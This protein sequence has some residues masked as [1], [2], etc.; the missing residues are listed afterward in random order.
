MSFVRHL[1]LCLWKT[2]LQKLRNPVSA[3]AELLL[4]VVLVG[5]WVFLYT[6]S[7]LTFMPDATH[8]CNASTI[9]DASTHQDF[10]YLPRALNILN[11]KLAVVGPPELTGPFY[12][13]LR[14]TYP[15]IPAA[16]VQTL[17]CQKSLGFSR[18]LGSVPRLVDLVVNFTTEAEMEAQITS[19]NYGQAASNPLIYAAIVWNRGPPHWDYTIRMNKTA[20]PDNGVATDPYLQGVQM[21]TQ[22]SYVS[23][24]PATDQ[25][26]QWPKTDP[27]IV[28]G[29][30]AIQLAVD[31]FVL[32]VREA[33]TEWAGLVTYNSTLAQVPSFLALWNCT[34]NIPLE[35]AGDEGGNIVT[36]I[37]DMMNFLQSHSFSP[38]QALLVPFPTASYYSTTFY[39]V[40]ANVFSLSFILFFFYPVSQLISGVVHEKETRIKEGMRMMGIPS[41]AL[42]AAWYI[43]YALAFLVASF[44]VSAVASKS[45]FGRSDSYVVWFMFWLFGLAAT[46]EA[47]LISVFFSRAKVASAVGTIVFLASF[48]PYYAVNDPTKPF[49]NKLGACFSAP[50][51]LGLNLQVLAQLESSGIGLHWSTAWLQVDG[52]T[53]GSGMLMMFLDTVLYTVIALYLEQVLPSEYGVPKPWYFPCTSR[54]WASC[55][56]CG[57][58]RIV[59]HAHLGGMDVEASSAGDISLQ[60]MGQDDSN[61]DNRPL[62]DATSDEEDHAYS[63][64]RN[65]E[66]LGPDRRALKAAGRCVSARNLQKHFQTPDGIRKAVDGVDLDVFQGEIFALLGHNGAG[67]STT[68]S[69]LTGLIPMS[70]GAANAFGLDVRTDMDQLR[71]ILGVCPQHD[72]LW[73]ELTVQEHLTFFAAAKGVPPGEVN[74]AVEETIKEVG[75]TEKRTVQSQALSGGMKRKLSVG[76]ALIGG[77]KLVVLDEPTSGMDPYSR[78]STW[79]ILLSSKSDRA[80]ILSTHFLDEA[81]LLGDR[82]AIMASGK[83]RC[84]GSSM[85]LKK[86]YGV[87]YNLTVNKADESVD[88]DPV[89]ALIRKHVSTV[90]DLSN[91]GAEIAFQV[92][93]DASPRF[94]ALFEE[95]ESKK[96]DLGVRSYSIGVTTL[97]EVFLRVAEEEHHGAS[98][99]TQKARDEAKETSNGF[100]E[101]PSSKASAAAAGGY[102]PPSDAKDGGAYLHPAAPAA[103]ADGWDFS[104]PVAA[105]GPKKVKPKVSHKE[106]LA[107]ARADAKG[108][109]WRH[110]YALFNKRLRYAMRDLRAAIFQ[111]LIPVLALLAGLLLLKLNPVQLPPPIAFN[112]SSLN[113]Q[114]HSTS[115]QAEPWSTVMQ[116]P[117][118]QN[119]SFWS[120]LV[121]STPPSNATF[122]QVPQP[123]LDAMYPVTGN[124]TVDDL[125]HCPAL[126]QFGVWLWNPVDCRPDTINSSIFPFKDEEWSLKRQSLAERIQSLSAAP[127]DVTPGA[128]VEREVAHQPNSFASLLGVEAGP[129]A[130]TIDLI[131]QHFGTHRVLEAATV[132]KEFVSQLR[133]GQVEVQGPAGKVKPSG[134]FGCAKGEWPHP[135]DQAKQFGEYLLN[136]RQSAPQGA[137]VYAALNVTKFDIVPGQARKTPAF[138]VSNGSAGMVLYHNT[139]ANHAIPTFINVFTSAAW[140]FLSGAGSSAQLASVTARSNPVPFTQ[141]EKS[142]QNS[143]SSFVAVLFI[144]LAFAFIPASFAVF[145]VR[146]REVS[147]KHLQLIS[148]VSIPAYWSATFCWDIANYAVPCSLSIVLVAAFNVQELIEGESLAAT[149]LLFVLY[150]IS[151]AAFT[152][153]LSYLFTSHAT[154]QIVVLVLNLLCMILLIASFIMQQIDSTCDADRGLRYIYRFLPG[155][156]LGNGLLQLSLLKQLAFLNTDCSRGKPDYNPFAAPALT[157]FSADVA[158]APIGYMAAEA[159]LY[160]ILAVALDLILSSPASRAR[161]KPDTDTEQPPFEEDEDVKKERLR[162]ESG[163]AADDVIV[164]DGL[165]KVYGGE[166]AAIKQLSFGVGGGQVFGFL[167][168]NG[169]GK[170]TTM[171]VLTGDLIPTKGTAQLAGLDIL[172]DQLECRRMIGYCPQFDALLDLLTV[173]EHLELFARIKSV[174]EKEIEGVVRTKLEEMDLTDFENKLAGSLSGG[175]KR[176]LSVAI[177][178]ISEP[179]LVMLDEPSTGV[180][181]VARRFMWDVIARYLGSSKTVILVTHSMEEVEALCNNVGI[182]VG[183]RLRCFGP[184]SHLKERFGKGYMVEIKLNDPD[185]GHSDRVLTFAAPFIVDRD[186]ATESTMPGADDAQRLVQ[187][188]AGRIPADKIDA[189]CEALGDPLR[190]KMIHPKG[191]GWALANDLATNGFMD[192][193]SFADWWAFESVGAHLHHFMI[194]TFPDTELVE[195]HGEFFRYSIASGASSR[196]DRLPL[197]RIFRA[198]E[199]AKERLRISTYSLSQTTLEAVFNSFAAQ[200]E[201]ELGAVRGMTRATGP[202]PASPRA[203]RTGSIDASDLDELME[204]AESE[205]GDALLGAVA[206]VPGLRM[207]AMSASQSR[208]WRRSSSGAGASRVSI[209]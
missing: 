140:R 196:K 38:L 180:D 187:L 23:Y 106:I 12:A 121:D 56:L 168:C 207:D 198:L 79:N 78:R 159:V 132:T 64:T 112:T 178:L 98:G 161:C 129:G 171:K 125:F 124:Y 183:G 65:F 11:R 3:C 81:D 58:D 22:D 66:G 104:K 179:P 209:N 189:L 122:V 197:S 195:R 1:I 193:A 184:I 31:K 138:S 119:N 30:A 153:C 136:H 192:A 110:F 94:P 116:V 69:M 86:R 150:G 8:E 186:G 41:A 208:D 42:T 130:W 28:P 87:G 93:T 37:Q 170:T 46:A 43:T 142:I 85:F 49:G 205:I 109:F 18:P 95:L 51:A 50:V 191:S 24:D 96:S 137:S 182:M 20:T 52:F 157:A 17:G 10:I 27:V 16:S 82:I 2:W 102:L 91:V 126:L 155:Y 160:F 33:P 113:T 9:L 15:G 7:P 34:F 185:E 59:R 165:R 60:G 57:K 29:F 47:F 117:I 114:T 111:L 4:P 166:K 83:V 158:G 70:A 77:S 176:K 89:A 103:G 172:R 19:D 53:A 100:Y 76:I 54:F 39:Q 61:S 162:V 154:A 120:D 156:S 203:A 80:I 144:T 72:V 169:A 164:F 152:Y 62:L 123:T 194:H 92:P 190:A 204:E 6:Q 206:G 32:G 139:T 44:G 71:K 105:S 145:V 143:A 25:F 181:P 175:N 147:A 199:A 148:G 201:E 177:A 149:I 5:A 55:G 21:T 97:E 67:K 118:Y 90:K 202:E 133:T 135:L 73:P 108:I 200:Q 99:A 13:H 26:Y 173:R 88:S 167:G 84:C 174:P 63:D 40:A 115:P 35:T 163:K 14:D 48:F 107:E 151:V 128:K 141:E 36:A 127:E 188:R 45:M 75:L 68:M 134:L 146:E 131:A 101:D 74:D